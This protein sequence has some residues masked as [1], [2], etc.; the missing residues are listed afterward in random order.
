MSC[1]PLQVYRTKWDCICQGF[2]VHKTCSLNDTYGNYVKFRW[3]IVAKS[4]WPFSNCQGFIQVCLCPIH[5]GTC[6]NISKSH[7][8]F[9]HAHKHFLANRHGG[10]TAACFWR[11]MT[12]P[13]LTPYAPCRKTGTLGRCRSVLR[14][15]I[16]Q[17][18]GQISQQSFPLSRG[19]KRPDECHPVSTALEKELVCHLPDSYSLSTQA[20][21]RQP[22]FLSSIN[23]TN[24]KLFLVSLTLIPAS[25]DSDW[26]LDVASSG[27][28]KPPLQRGFLTRVVQMQTPLK[29][30]AFLTRTP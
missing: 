4:V 29:G 30:V 8:Q 5:P 10:L 24:E 6:G 27:R 1:L 7:I 2:M 15:G 25:S 28:R 23:F 21:S 19:H 18:P 13:A 22:R 17:T 11:L 26:D 14:P 12:S 9:S 20:H 3:E 16:H